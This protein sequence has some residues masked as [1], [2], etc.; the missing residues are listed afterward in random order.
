LAIL[1]SFGAGIPRAEAAETAVSK[2]SA[3]DTR[4][5]PTKSEF[6]GARFFE[7]VGGD[8]GELFMLV[9]DTFRDLGDVRDCWGDWGGGVF[10]T[11]ER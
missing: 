6:A 3:P 7:A 10:V 11:L 5:P 4:L 8:E 1:G 2:L 9:D